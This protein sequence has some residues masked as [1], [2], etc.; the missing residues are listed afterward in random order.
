AGALGIRGCA[1]IGNSMGG[2][3][4]MRLALRDP[5]A[6]GPLVN[7]HSPGVPLLRLYA[8]RTVLSAP[9]SHRLLRFLVHRDPERWVHRNVHYYDESLKSREE[10][11]EYAEPLATDAGVA[12]FARILHETLDPAE[13][14]AFVERLRLL[15]EAGQPF[16]VP[17]MLVYAAQD[18]MVPPSVGA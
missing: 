3:L 7:L 14:R 9:G 18:P 17:L 11:R 15:S 12:A 4:C 10:T 2:Y 13:M 16:P 8:L 1:A 5:E 6:L